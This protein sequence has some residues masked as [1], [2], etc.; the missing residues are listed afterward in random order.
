MKKLVLGGSKVD[1]IGMVKELGPGNLVCGF[2]GQ[3]C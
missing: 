1:A 2:M 3:I